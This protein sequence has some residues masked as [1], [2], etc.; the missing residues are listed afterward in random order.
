MSAAKQQS[1][2]FLFRKKFWIRFFVAILLIPTIL[3]S[4]L[5]GIVYYKQDA[6]VQELLTQFNEDF[7]GSIQMKDS[8]ISLFE[9]F[10]YISIDLEDL[11]IYEDKSTSKKSEIAHLKDSYIGF[12][13]FD[14]VSGNIEIKSLHIKKGDI[15][16]VQEKDGTLNLLN[17][18]KSKKPE[19]E[20]EKDFKIKLK[21]FK[22]EDINLSKYNELNRLHINSHLQTVDTEIEGSNKHFD[23]NLKTNFELSVTKDGKKTFLKN[24]HFNLSTILKLDQTKKLLTIEPTEV[25]LEQSTFNIQGKVGLLKN[26]P[27]DLKFEGEKQNFNL[28][29]DLAPTEIANALNQFKNKGKVYFRG[30]V[31]G[32]SANGRT[33][34]IDIEFGCKN[35]AFNNKKTE[36]TLDQI[37][38]SG[39][40][41]NG[42]N[43]D[44][45]TSELVI[46]HFS[47]RPE[48]GLFNGDLAIKN[49]NSPEIRL[50]LNANFNLDFIARFINLKEFKGLKGKVLLKLNFHDIIDL[51][52]PEKSINK[53]NESYSTELTIENFNIENTEF[54]IPLRDLNV[55]AVMKGH[56]AKIEHLN[57][58]L[59]ETDLKMN[60]SISD[61]PA[62]LHSKSIPI[63]CN[64]NIQSEHINFRE[65][66][67][68]QSPIETNEKIEDFKL[69]LKFKTTGFDLRNFK[70]L[71]KGEFFIRNF[72]AKFK[73]YPHIIHDFF[74]DIIIADKDFKIIDFKGI[75]DQ[76]DFHFNGFLRN[77][78]LYFENETEGNIYLEFD[79]DSK[80]LI[81]ENLLSY[82][83]INYL[84]PEYRHEEI[85][86]LLFHGT[87]SMYFSSG[88]LKSIEFD[89]SNFSGK[90]KIHPLK[91]ENFS[92]KI[93]INNDLIKIAHFKG[94]MGKSNFE[95]NFIHFW[96]LNDHS[97][98]N[99]LNLSADFIDI[100][101]I[102]NYNPPPQYDPTSS[103]YVDL[104]PEFSLFDLPF[105]NISSKIQVKKLN[106]HQHFLDHFNFEFES[107]H[108]KTYRI[109]KLSFQTAEGAIAMN[110]TL[111]A[112]NYDKI[113]F[114]PN[115]K[116]SH[117]DLDKFMLKFENFGQ[118]YVVSDNLHGYFNGE[119]SG[120][121]HLNP[122]L[123][124]KIDDSEL[125][126][127]MLV[128]EG[129]IENFAP[130]KVLENYFEDKNLNRVAFDTL[131]NEISVINGIVTIP[132]MTINST[133][134]FM[135]ISGTQKMTSLMEMDYIIGV[136]WKMIG[137]VAA[138]KLFKRNKENEASEDEIQYKNEKS[139][140]VY[141]T[142]KGSLYDYQ[143]QL[144]RKKK[145][146]N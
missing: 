27:M 36:K 4:V 84:P 108:K 16:L 140:F 94:K 75:L 47:A 126:I 114:T 116:I 79:I 128:T 21:S 95:L 72:Y 98:L 5:L 93:E 40:F 50:G 62:V 37:D 99:Y 10:P 57:L 109:K 107:N 90:M 89:L 68:F 102:I 74:A 51:G 135:E 64:L 96:D 54:K 103:H 19:E 13:L 56:E 106:Y 63:T 118:D 46:N 30:K 38:F 70:Y 52:A 6:I 92:S 105:Y 97:K 143:V 7:E 43:H 59:G 17:A 129:K 73:Q 76:S 134:G 111:H 144:I 23:L 122:D 61:L 88:Q 141:L 77:Y 69:N 60:G 100:D 67:S 120:L 138:N 32:E 42:K 139:K 44:L 8:H 145:V 82:N 117:L 35:G 133:L 22:L 146:K 112:S 55:R 71:P 1:S 137:N 91:F 132:K 136:P 20:I 110:G 58:I 28:F 142:L 29:V 121:I 25:K 115:I 18:L 3:L 41:T 119:I 65:L 125:L 26:V 127:K 81:L 24:K 101:E 11:Y 85:D 131:Q 86:Q 78:H 104:Q 83:G 14:I 45:S 39:N 49:F 124:P 80:K 33:P 34:K 31:K 53:L 12:S 130:L 48:I 9:S 15:K 113:Y 123:T 66:F 2:F 87:T